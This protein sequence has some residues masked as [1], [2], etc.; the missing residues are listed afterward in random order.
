MSWLKI[1]A[2]EMRGYRMRA[3]N[4][5]LSDIGVIEI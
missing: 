2:K 4:Y 3:F 5:R 1:E